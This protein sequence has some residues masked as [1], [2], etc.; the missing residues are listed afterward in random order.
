MSSKDEDKIM[1]LNAEIAKNE[2]RIKQICSDHWYVDADTRNSRI[3][4]RNMLWHKYVK[5]S[6]YFRLNEFKDEELNQEGIALLLQKLNEGTI[7]DKEI[8]IAKHIGYDN[9]YFS[10]RSGE[11]NDFLILMDDSEWNGANY[12][13]T[14]QN[15]IRILEY[16]LRS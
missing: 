6:G 9:W 15:M 10:V 8:L 11:T 5:K 13:I 12:P 7:I 16:L 14:K 1:A 2:E 4:L 3:C